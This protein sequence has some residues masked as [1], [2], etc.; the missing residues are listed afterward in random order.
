MFMG[1]IFTQHHLNKSC[2]IALFY[3]TVCFQGVYLIFKLTYSWECKVNTYVE[4]LHTCPI[5]RQIYVWRC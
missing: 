1:E 4:I 2:R 5:L 3:G